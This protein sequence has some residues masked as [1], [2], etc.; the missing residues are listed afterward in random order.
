M[1]MRRRGFSALE[2]AMVLAVISAMTMVV[3]GLNG[4]AADSARKSSCMSNLKQFS[5]AAAMYAMDYDGHYPPL[6]YR[7]MMAY[8][9]NQQIFRCPEVRDKDEPT[10]AGELFRSM[11]PEKEGCESDFEVN[12]FYSPGHTN[13]DMPQTTLFYDDVAD[14]H[15]GGSFNYVRIDGAT[16]NAPASAWPGKPAGVP[17]F[18]PRLFIDE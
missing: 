14:R 4:R 7:T 6:D 17:E 5:T 11:E 2:L 9:K 12:Y 16:K 15:A 3:I 1:V 18:P 8:V 13:D 10:P